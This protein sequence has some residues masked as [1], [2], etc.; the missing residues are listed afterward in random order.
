[1]WQKNKQ[2]IKASRV[3]RHLLLDN[4]LHREINIGI[5]SDLTVGDGEKA[6]RHKVQ[7]PVQDNL[8]KNVNVRS[9]VTSS[10]IRFLNILFLFIQQFIIANVIF[11]VKFSEIRWINF[12]KKETRFF[13]S[14]DINATPTRYRQ[15]TGIR[16][17]IYRVYCTEKKKVQNHLD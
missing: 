12:T 4:R 8:V 11:G 16:N 9:S 2:K 10:K 3:P 5:K 1:M 6:K 14:A 15:Y 7:R 13:S 17:K